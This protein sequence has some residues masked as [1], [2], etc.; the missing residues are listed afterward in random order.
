MCALQLVAQGTIAS[1]QICFVVSSFNQI[2]DT[3]QVANN[4]AQKRSEKEIQNPNTVELDISNKT[5]TDN[6]DKQASKE[7]L[8][9][10]VTAQLREDKFVAALS[11]Q[12]NRKDPVY[13]LGAKPE[14]RATCNTCKVS[15]PNNQ[16]WEV[17]NRTEDHIR[18]L[19][20][21]KGETSAI[22]LL[23]KNYSKNFNLNCEICG[24][25]YSDPLTYQAHKLNP[26]HQARIRDVLQWRRAALA[27]QL[28]NA[29]WNKI[30]K[31]NKPTAKQLS[32]AIWFSTR[33]G[34]K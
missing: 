18:A 21:Q 4:L 5:D 27:N 20:V 30:A 32:K 33:K 12:I 3:A 16:S 11:G 29:N 28:A 10:R 14:L 17:H 2:S 6:S 24:T 22:K 31:P 9:N 13:A 26:E 25:W 1:N 7:E 23:Y 8:K 15:K 34:K 19:F